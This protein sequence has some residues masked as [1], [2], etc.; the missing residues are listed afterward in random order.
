[1]EILVDAFMRFHVIC[2][3]ARASNTETQ[4]IQ[5]AATTSENHE[6]PQLRDVRAIIAIKCNPLADIYPVRG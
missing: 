2:V 4:S 3:R 5:D 1:M 6:T